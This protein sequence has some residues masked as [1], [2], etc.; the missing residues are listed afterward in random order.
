MKSPPVRL[1]AFVLL[2]VFIG[3]VQ[4]SRTWV[5]LSKNSNNNNSAAQGLFDTLRQK[6]TLSSSLSGASR[7]ED[8]FFLGKP[9]EQDPNNIKN[10]VGG[11]KSG[12]PTFLSTKS[13]TTMTTDA[14][15]AA[16]M[17]STRDSP[18]AIRDK[19]SYL[20]LRN[21]CW[22]IHPTKADTK[23]GRFWFFSLFWKI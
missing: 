2:L 4:L 9:E 16:D 12:S 13:L 21:V 19:I 3:A 22:S 10:M 14:R 11:S 17:S 23:G 5:S 8:H 18:N 7:I 1:A 20:E 15:N 6:S